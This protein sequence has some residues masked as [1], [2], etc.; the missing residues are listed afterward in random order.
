MSSPDL[1]LSLPVPVPG[2][3]VGLVLAAM[4]LA[5][6]TCFW[7][8]VGGLGLFSGMFLHTPQIEQYPAIAAI[9]I[10][11]S[12][13]ILTICAF[14][15]FT[16]VG[17]FRV[18]NWARISILIL[19]GLL[20]FISLVSAIGYAV[21]AMSSLMDQPDTS[22]TSPIALKFIFLS[23]SSVSLVVML[24]GVWW[25]VYFNLRRIR[26]LFATRATQVLPDPTVAMPM[27]VMTPVP[28]PAKR[29]RSV[30]ETLMIGLAVLYV[31]GVAGFIFNAVLQV[32]IF[33]LGFIFRGTAAMVLMLAFSVLNLWVGIGLLRRMKAAWVGAFVINGLG[34]LSILGLVLPSVR[35]RMAAYQQEVMRSMFHGALPA[36]PLNQLLQGPVYVIS[37]L[38]GI[39]TVGAVIWLLVL[40]KP[41][42]EPGNP[43]D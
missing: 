13:A 24:I 32:P 23:M 27:P 8:M 43:P 30:I 42:F 9:Q 16:V 35:A 41:L 3:P 15:V 1:A 11:S 18:K 2:R 7:L 25:L 39:L 6:M 33:F 17:L 20:A 26:A 21:M 40:A 19:G 5:L 12:L 38:S 28:I 29:G 37:A 22:G 31:L 4:S 36:V 10:A 14:C 34:L